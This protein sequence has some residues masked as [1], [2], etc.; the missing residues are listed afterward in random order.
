[1]VERVFPEDIG[2]GRQEA[3]YYQRLLLVSKLDRAD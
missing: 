3:L 1:M 2:V